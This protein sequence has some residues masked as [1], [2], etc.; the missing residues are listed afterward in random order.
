V[1][2]KLLVG[3]D[4]IPAS[5]AACVKGVWPRLRADADAA[6]VNLARAADQIG[7]ALGALHKAMRDG[8]PPPRGAHAIAELLRH[9]RARA[10]RAQLRL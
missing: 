9:T 3:A 6:R 8:W 1:K 4:G 2:R 10:R 5:A 7:K